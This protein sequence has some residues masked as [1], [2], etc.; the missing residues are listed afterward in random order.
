MSSRSAGP[1]RPPARR[2]HASPRGGHPAALGRSDAVASIS[3]MTIKRAVMRAPSSSECAS[4]QA[5]D[6]AHQRERLFDPCTFAHGTSRR[7]SLR[8]PHSEGCTTCKARSSR[9][10]RHRPTPTAEAASPNDDGKW[11]HDGEKFIDGIYKITCASCA[12]VLYTTDDCP[13]CHAAGALPRA[14]GDTSRLVAPKRFAGCNELELLALALVPAITKSAPARPKPKALVEFGEPGHHLVAYACESCDAAIVTQKC[15]LCDAPDRCDRGRDQGFGLPSVA[16]HSA[17]SSCNDAHVPAAVLKSSS[18]SATRARAARDRTSRV[19]CE[20]EF[21]SGE[22]AGFDLERLERCDRAFEILDRLALAPDDGP[23]DGALHEEARDA[24]M[25]FAV[26]AN[27]D[28]KR[29]V[30]ECECLRGASQ[31][32]ER[33]TLRCPALRDSARAAAGSVY[34]APP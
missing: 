23:E 18:D 17:A 11:V 15:P 22:V 8:S 30:D 5:H 12:H 16:S 6:F 2:P 28:R 19:L 13:R 4:S 25:C 10:G 32:V 29:F 1:P 33:D 7:A 34:R 20:R 24:R 27:V 3:I 21:R 31:A 26:D 14:L 9:S